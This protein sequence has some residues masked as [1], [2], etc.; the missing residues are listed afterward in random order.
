MML[1]DL[2]GDL[3]ERRTLAE[4]VFDLQAFKVREVLV[5]HLCGSFSF[6]APCGIAM[7]GQGSRRTG[8]MA[9]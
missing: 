6:V 7:A 4:S 9:D 5:L 3:L 8:K 2:L 1:A